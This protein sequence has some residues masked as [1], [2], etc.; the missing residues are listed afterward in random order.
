MVHGAVLAKGG[1]ADTAACPGAGNPGTA[2][3]A[4]NGT[5]CTESG[6][7]ALTNFYPA[8]NVNGIVNASGLTSQ[9]I[10]NV[11][12][13]NPDGYAFVGGRVRVLGGTNP[14]N[15]SFAYTAAAANA[16]PVVGAVVTTGC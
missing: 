1:I 11:A 10:T 2:N 16:A 3:N 8:A 6:R 12:Q 13:L 9:W 4:A 15:C 14:V 7:V 5:V